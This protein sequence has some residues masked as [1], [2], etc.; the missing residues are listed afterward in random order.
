MAKLSLGLCFPSA[1]QDFEVHWPRACPTRYGPPAGFGYPLDDLRPRNPRR[2]YFRPAALVGF[3][4]RRFSFPCG[5][6]KF[7]ISA[8]PTYRWNPALFP[9]PS[10]RTGPPGLDFWVHAARNR[11]ATMNRL[12][13]WPRGSSLGFAPFRACL[14]KP[15]SDFSN[16]PLTCL[17]R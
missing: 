15:S 3:P 9:M 4:L 1:H 6:P 7:F 12:S 14:R 17:A 10:H 5:L 8:K 11:L 13:P 2:P 16:D